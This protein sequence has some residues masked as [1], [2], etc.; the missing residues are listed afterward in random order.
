MSYAPK[1]R[2]TNKGQS[3]LLFFMILPLTF[4]AL[5]QTRYVYRMVER[6]IALQTGV[7]L[8]LMT[9]TQTLVEGLNEISRLN[10]KLLHLHALLKA[11]QAGKILSGHHPGFVISEALLKKIIQLI[12]KKQD[13]IMLL[14]PKLAYVHGYRVARKNQTPH[15]MMMPLT[16]T[17]P[18]TR[19]QW[20]NLPG[21]LQLKNNFFE[22]TS[23]RAMGQKYRFAYRAHAKMKLMGDS[24]NEA[25]WRN[26]FE[27]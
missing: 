10:Q 5:H 17:Y 2:F 13:L 12:A 4:L 26:V 20:G 1:Q 22:N 6:K 3:T 7:D 15:L 23:F 27:E 24:L 18:M 19:T 16:Y 14:Y 21:P 11:V 25:T 8:T 9:V